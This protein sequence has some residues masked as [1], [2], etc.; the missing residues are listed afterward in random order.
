MLYTEH[1][2]INI[3]DLNLKIKKCERQRYESFAGDSATSMSQVLL[4]SAILDEYFMYFYHLIR[5]YFQVFNPLTYF[6]EIL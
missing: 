6:R 3:N 2:K 1:L 5:E 4:D